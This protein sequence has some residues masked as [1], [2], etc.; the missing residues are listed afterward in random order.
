MSWIHFSNLSLSRNFTFFSKLSHLLAYNYSKYSHNPFNFR[1]NVSSSVPDSEALFLSSAL[2][3]LVKGLSSGWSFNLMHSNAFTT[4][5]LHLTFHFSISP[6]WLWTPESRVC[7]HPR[8]SHLLNKCL[9]TE[10][11]MTWSWGRLGDL[12]KVM[13]L[14]RKNSRPELYSLSFNTALSLA[15]QSAR[16]WERNGLGTNQ[17]SQASCQPAECSLE[18]GPA[19]GPTQHMCI[20]LLLCGFG[21]IVPNG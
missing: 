18:P 11:R 16:M 2:I 6:A 13:G 4:L 12:L 17:Y 14:L 7:I 1:S 19:T 10:W 8:L 5:D 21:D 20:E 3:S 9:W 15:S